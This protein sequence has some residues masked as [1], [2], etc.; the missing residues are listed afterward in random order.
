MFMVTKRLNN[1]NESDRE[2][3][4]IFSKYDQQR[5]CI[6]NTVKN[7]DSMR[8]KTSRKQTNN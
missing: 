3:E 7:S 4:N 5:I 2:L 1:T 8:K 6:C